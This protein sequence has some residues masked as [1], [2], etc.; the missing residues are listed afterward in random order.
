[1]R[2]LSLLKALVELKSIS[3]VAEHEHIAQPSVSIQLKKLSELLG[4][5]L[6]EVQGRKVEITEA[7][8]VIYQAALEVE[9]SMDRMHSKLAALQGL[10]AGTLRLAVVSTAQYFMPLM[11]G[12][13]YRR[14]PNIDVQLTIGNREEVIGRLQQNKDDF[15]MFSH[16]PEELDIVKEPLM[17]NSLVVLAPAE[18][19]LTRQTHISL[20]RLQH[21]PFIMR[22][23]GSGTRRSIE[24]FCQQHG[25]QLKE[26]MTIESNEAIKQAVA[27]GLGLSILSRH[28][29]DYTN[30][31]G[32]VRLKVDEFPITSEWYLVHKKKRK[33]SMLAKTF[34][35]FIQLEGKGVLAD[36][37]NT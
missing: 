15:Y 30:I 13:F 28:T 3:R 23:R 31:K 7:G 16:C 14:Y 35:D 4:A 29:L 5:E 37:M 8:Q 34:H 24:L 21:Y 6:Y 2:Q 36:K 1:M 10:Q 27:S 9:A 20:Q 18:H 26:R 25:I 33:L 17:D 12:P 11:L 19:E 22:E 32:L